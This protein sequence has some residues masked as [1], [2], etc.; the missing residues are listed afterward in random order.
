MRTYVVEEDL[1]VKMLC[2]CT[3]Q[4]TRDDWDKIQSHVY[5]EE[6]IV[7]TCSFL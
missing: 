4:E 2:S 1:M 6:V 7:R 3:P 5:V